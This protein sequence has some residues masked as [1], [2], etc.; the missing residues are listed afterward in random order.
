MDKIYL[1]NKSFIEL[2]NFVSNL[3]FVESK[4]DAEFY[5]LNYYNFIKKDFNIKTIYITNDSKVYCLNIELIK[6][7]YHKYFYLWDIND[8]NIYKKIKFFFDYLYKVSL[9][10]LSVFSKDIF[11]NISFFSSLESITIKDFLNFDKNS[12]NN[13]I[14]NEIDILSPSDLIISDK[15]KRIYK[16][17]NSNLYEN[18]F[19]KDIILSLIPIKYWGN[20]LFFLKSKLVFKMHSFFHSY[21][22][23]ISL[24]IPIARSKF[25]KDLFESLSLQTNNKFNIYIWVDWYNDY[26]KKKIIKLIKKYKDKFYKLNYFINRKNLW[27]WKTRWKLMRKDINSKY[28]IFL[29]DDVFLDYEA[30]Q[31]LYDIINENKNV[32]LYSIENIDVRY[33]SD[34][35]DYIFKKGFFHNTHYYS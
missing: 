35:L 8:N 14:I 34:Y 10:N 33:D 5:N 18:I 28:I 11:L 29:D 25:L 17:I 4:S 32:G 15:L 20:S 26:E 9:H 16:Y 27:V 24:Q 23:I 21:D 7:K 31:N 12:K 22:D 6:K 3:E 19:F 13:Y 2:T 1:I 30:I